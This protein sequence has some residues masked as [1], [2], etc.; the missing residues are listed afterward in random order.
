MAEKAKSTEAGNEPS[1]AEVQANVSNQVFGFMIGFMAILMAIVLILASKMFRTYISLRRLKTYQSQEITLKSL[2]DINGY[3]TGVDKK[4][5]DF[6]I[7][8]A[9]RPYV[10]YYHKY[11]YVSVEIFKEI[12]RCGPRMVELEVF[13]SNFGDKV[14]PVVSVGDAKGEWK[15][16]LNSAPLKDFFTAIARVAF[17]PL[18][19]KVFKDPFIL[20]LNLKTNR[21]M[22]CLNKIHQYLYDELGQFLLGT[23][24][25]YNDKNNNFTNITLDKC[26][27]R[28]IIMASTG[29][30]G[31]NLEELVNYSTVSNYTLQFAK[32]QRRVLYLHQDYIVETEEDIEDFVNSQHH[33]V[34]K[35]QVNKYNECSFTILSPGESNTGIFGG[36]S[37]LN[38]EV[39]K[40]LEA[41][42]QFI[43]ANYQKLDT[44]MR[45]YMYVFKDTSMVEKAS[46]STT[47]N[48]KIFEGIKE[49]KVNLNASEINY[50]YASTK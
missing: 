25:S 18:T 6:Y 31:T 48:N 41:G 7:A 24:Y 44:N 2:R 22:K 38:Y 32:N 20:Y 46:S 39:G 42:C 11:D 33:K 19:C 45:H 40:G 35:D 36:I 1:A 16:T 14:E 37:P 29:F 12:L 50:L 5:R 10:C 30:E 23:E 47:C 9:Y 21:N 34:A 26:Y 17:N 8:S 3:N 28:V 49:E 13:N 27:G 43:M 4:L 15:Y